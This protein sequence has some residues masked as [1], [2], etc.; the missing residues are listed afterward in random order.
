MR[1]GIETAAM[2]MNEDVETDTSLSAALRRLR[3]EN[4][5]L[6]REV[7]ALHVY[8]TM[9][10]FDA[11]TGLHNRRYFDERLREECARADRLRTHE[12]SVVLV[13]V[14]DFKS[15]NDDYGHATGDEV[16]VA[17]AKL[18]KENVREVDICCRIGGDEFAL[19]LPNTG[20][21]GAQ[22]V[23][24]RLR[25]RLA[26]G[27]LGGPVNVGLSIGAAACP[28]GP[29]ALD[30]LISQADTAMYLDKRRRK[31][32]RQRLAAV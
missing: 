26:Q 19:L 17:V 18:L 1:D 23:V 14:D 10:Y 9:A 2:V 5:A 3:R 6:R 7:Q 16:L 32:P 11:L 8:R 30:A 29:A 4:A 13:D 22:V 28:P 31:Q 21:Q 24:E 12:F 25:S 15:V 27:R 20:E